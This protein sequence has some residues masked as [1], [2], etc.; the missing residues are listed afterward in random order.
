MFCCKKEC[1]KIYLELQNMKKTIFYIFIIVTMVMISGFTYINNDNGEE[2]AYVFNLDSLYDYQK[3]YKTEELSVC[4][5]NTAKTYMDYRMTTVV[6]S[7][8]YQ[9]LNYKCYVDKTTGFLYDE[10]GFIAVALGSYYGEIGDRFYFTLDSGIVLPLVKGEEKADEDTDYTGCYHK[11]DGSVIE[12]VIDSDYA[13][14]YFFS[15]DNGLVLNGNYNNYS[16]FRG[17]I[18]KVEKVLDEK[19]EKNVTYQIDQEIPKSIDIF[20]YASGY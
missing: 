1:I 17:S 9:F 16:L 6:D 3:E 15:N 19:V 4:S 2:K 10:D 14:R 12:F 11:Y 8:Q 18:A 13:G 5:T 7:R 20:N